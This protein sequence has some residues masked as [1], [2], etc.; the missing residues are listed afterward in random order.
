MN[1]NPQTSP[2]ANFW[3]LVKLFDRLLTDL[4]HE[5]PSREDLNHFGDLINSN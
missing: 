3:F 5:P 2:Q 1:P 4:L